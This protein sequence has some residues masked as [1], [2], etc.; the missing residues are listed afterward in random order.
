MEEMTIDLRPFFETPFRWWRLILVCTLVPTIFTAT[1]STPVLTPNTFE[2]RAGVAVLR[3]RTQVD[4]ESAAKTLTDDQFQ[5]TA[6]GVAK[7]ATDSRQLTLAAL[8]KNGAIAERVLKQLEQELAEKGGKKIQPGD[9]MNLVSGELIQDQKQAKGDLV[10]VVVSHLDPVKAALIANA[11]AKE[12]EKLVNEIYGS[13]QRAET[14]ANVKLTKQEYEAAQQKLSQFIAESRIEQSKRQVEDKTKILAGLQDMR[15]RIISN[16]LG[17]EVSSSSQLYAAYLQAQADN[18]ILAFNKEQE[19]KRLLVSAYIDAQTEG[20]VSVFAKQA[21]ERQRVLDDAYLAQAKVDSFLRRAR[22]LRDQARQGGDAGST[23]VALLLLKAEIAGGFQPSQP[24][25]PSQP[26]VNINPQ[27]SQTES[28]PKAAKPQG[29]LDNLVILNNLTTP[30]SP[31]AQSN[32]SLN[33]DKIDTLVPAN[34]TQ[35]TEALVVA[36]D[37]QQNE[38]K[39]T[40][41]RQ[42]QLLLSD[43]G[44]NLAQPITDTALMQQIKQKYPQL[45]EPGELGKLSEAVTSDNSLNRSALA[46][47]EDLLQLKNKEK[48]LDF[49]AAD[50]ALNR[51]INDLEKE[52]RILESKVEEERSKKKDLER[53]RD[54]AFETFSTLARKEAEFRV[55]A[56]L[57]GTEVRF[58]SSATVPT[59]PSQKAV[60]RKQLN[61]GLS[62]F[63]GFLFGVIFAFMLEYLGSTVTIPQ[64]LWGKPAAPWNRVFRWLTKRSKLPRERLEE[65]AHPE[66]KPPEPNEGIS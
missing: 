6:E 36:L 41:E 29:S 30:N 35:D 16:T 59:L 37:N 50:T 15:Q 26:S 48:I 39:A 18:R 63:M 32:L 2:A 34:L 46:V 40:I 55:A 52:T 47:A 11:W 43:T 31:Q 60:T 61:L 24:S 23:S 9:L 12:Y 49:Y 17:L 13:P 14:Q 5:K 20:Q 45:F 33:I 3:S 44:L 1:A 58:A 65:L 8:V 22:T 4:F 25:T 56:E 28:D 66:E 7:T 62:S 27:K 21:K 64:V 42:A 54:L 10:E 38:L 57:P 51:Y 19:R 53:A